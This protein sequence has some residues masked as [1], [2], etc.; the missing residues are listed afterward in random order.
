MISSFLRSWK[1]ES[2]VLY[3]DLDREE[4]LA[5]IKHYRACNDLKGFLERIFEKGNLD[6]RAS[7]KFEIEAT[8]FWQFL[9]IPG[10]GMTS[11]VKCILIKNGDKTKIEALVKTNTGLKFFGLITLSFMNFVFFKSTSSYFDIILFALCNFLY[12]SAYLYYFKF[13]KTRLVRSLIE[14]FQL[15]KVYF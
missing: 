13:S 6:I 7:S 10:I 3:S 2:L 8:M 5:K 1:T 11:S 15:K 4:F 14:N 12:I 9:D